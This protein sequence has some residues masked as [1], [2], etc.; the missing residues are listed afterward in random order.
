MEERTA[1]AT[2]WG[3]PVVEAALLARPPS[4]KI[5]HRLRS[6]HAGDVFPFPHVGEY[7]AVP[8][9]SPLVHS[10]SHAWLCCCRYFV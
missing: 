4:I 6:R 8:D 5:A 3:S 1:K 10:V 9:D 2:P 7:G